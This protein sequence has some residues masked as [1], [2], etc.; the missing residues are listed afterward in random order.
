MEFGFRIVERL[1]MLELLPQ[2]GNFLTLKE[3]RTLRENLSLSPEEI[4]DF[5][6]KQENNNIVWNAS[7]EQPK[8]VQISE[9]LL[10]E[11]KDKFKELDAEK[12]LTERY[13]SIYEKIMIE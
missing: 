2:E 13:L 10:K 6:V 11:L 1:V 8:Q 7:K 12:K 9:Y 4:K 5:E 3:V